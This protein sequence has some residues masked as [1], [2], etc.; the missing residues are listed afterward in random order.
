MAFSSNFVQMMLD[1]GFLSEELKQENASLKDDLMIDS[2][3]L[4]EI[5]MVIE[6][7]YQINVDVEELKSLETLKD[8]SAFIEKRISMEKECN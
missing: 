1:A 4:V 6:S 7:K 3:E 8:L 5:A 2:T